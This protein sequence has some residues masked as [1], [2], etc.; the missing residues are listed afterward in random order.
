MVY[1]IYDNESIV[2]DIFFLTNV[3][4]GRKVQIFCVYVQWRGVEKIL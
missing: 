1:V 3:I 4:E 2:L